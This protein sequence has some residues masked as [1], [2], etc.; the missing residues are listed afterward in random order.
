MSLQ[1]LGQPALAEGTTI[2]LEELKL[3]VARECCGLRMLMGIAALVA[4]YVVVARKSRWQKG[5]LLASV[6]PVAVCANVLR[7]TLTAM[8]FRYMSDR[9]AQSFSHDAAGW[10]TNGLAA[11]LF[12][13]VLWCTHR[14]FRETE[15]IS[16]NELLRRAGDVVVPY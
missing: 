8:L 2:I 13:G 9:A 16:P 3:D 10:I 12:A 15:T 14:L 7:L 4:A 11:G 6:L 1:C 5:V